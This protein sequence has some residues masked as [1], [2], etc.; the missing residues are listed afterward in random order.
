MSRRRVPLGRIV[1]LTAWFVVLWLLLWS[2]AS[3]ANVLSGL[4]IALAVA[5]GTA[6]RSDGP[7]D[8]GASDGTGVATRTRLAPLAILHFAGHVLWRLVAA[9]L[10]LAWTILTPHRRLATATMEVALL[11][12]SPL[13]MMAVSNVITL[14]PGSVTLDVTASPPTVTI[15]LLDLTDPEA[16]RRSVHRTEALAIRAFGTTAARA[17][18]RREVAP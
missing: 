12:D 16:A 7:A 15:G 1:A 18:L 17:A 9:N 3:P 5:A 10:E 14:T 13:V 8:G 11:T 6:L 4:V 2:D